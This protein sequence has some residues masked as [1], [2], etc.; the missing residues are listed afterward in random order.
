VTPCPKNPRDGEPPGI[1]RNEK[2][3]VTV[4]GGQKS[5]RPPHQKRR[6]GNTFSPPRLSR[7][8]EKGTRKESLN[9]S[10]KETKNGSSQAD[11]H[12]SEF[13]APPKRPRLETTCPGK[14]TCRK[15][16]WPPFERK[17]KR[18]KRN[19]REKG[20]SRV[21]VRGYW[22][23]TETLTSSVEKKSSGR[24]PQ[25]GL[26]NEGPTAISGRG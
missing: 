26:K 5:A 3:S 16:E 17:T 2:Q 8:F 18:Q 15:T 11:T 4:T 12:Q 6:G 10:A 19:R 14:K 21:L 23:R 1:L 13:A 20:S 9:W 24:Y 7:G 25:V 22:P